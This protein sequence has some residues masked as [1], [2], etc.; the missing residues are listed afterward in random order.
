MNVKKTPEVSA[1][2]VRAIS[3]INYLN[4]GSGSKGVGEISKDLGLSTTIVHRLLTT[5]KIEG[6]VFQDPRSKLYSLGTVFL[7]Y[8]N[9]ILTEVPIAP[10]V[11]PWLLSLRNET[12]ETVGFYMPTGQMRI[13]VLE[14]ESQQEIRRSVGMGKRLPIHVGASGR[15]ILAFQSTELQERVLSTRPPEERSRIEQL[16]EETRNQGYAT[17]EEEI[18]TNVAAISAPVF[19]PQ[20]RV[21]GA[22]SISGPLFRW[23]RKTMEPHISNLLAATK[24]IAYSL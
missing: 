23:N 21:I 13:C 8:A 22:I 4:E 3:I 24:E 11:E 5:L 17:N 10:V 15:A 2:V 6:M 9:K 19:D 1:T 16:L 14:Y 18:T 20:H 12:E 7:D